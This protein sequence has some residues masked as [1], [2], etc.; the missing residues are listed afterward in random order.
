MKKIILLF[1]LLYVQ[2]FLF[3]Q[4]YTITGKIVDSSSIG[5]KDIWISLYI[6]STYH[7]TISDVNGNF[8]FNNITEIEDENIP[9]GYSVSNN[10][11][12]PFNPTTRI[13]VTTPT[14]SKVRVNIYNLLG[15]KVSEE[16]QDFLGAGTNFLD[17]ELNGKPNGFYIAQIVLDEKY[18]I[19]KKL[20]LLYGSQ[21]WRTLLDF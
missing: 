5:L 17:L 21:H 13:A 9:T 15:Q 18:T 4:T 16:K 3:A 11:P 14:N 19:T 2:S 20:M 1:V 7:Y 10:Y 8:I 6:G 12:N